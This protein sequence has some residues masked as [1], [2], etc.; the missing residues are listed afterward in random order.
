MAMFFKIEGDEVVEDAELNVP[1]GADYDDVSLTPPSPAHHRPL[2]IRT[3]CPALFLPPRPMFF[4]LAGARTLAFPCHD[5]LPGL[6]AFPSL[7]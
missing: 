7:R 1:K 5:E 4:S 2:P 3:L 6:A